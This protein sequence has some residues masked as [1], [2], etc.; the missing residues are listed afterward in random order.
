VTLPQQVAD[1]AAQVRDL[2]GGRPAHLARTSAAAPGAVPLPAEWA[3]D[4]AGPVLAAPV[5]ASGRLA[6][7]ATALLT[8]G[9]G[10]TAAY[11]WQL[12]GPYLDAAGTPLHDSP[13]GTVG[14]ADERA[15]RVTAG[16]VAASYTW[17]HTGLHPG[18]WLLSARY[19]VTGGAGTAAGRL[20]LA[21]PL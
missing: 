11:S 17:E 5:G 2:R 6:V 13:A 19:R 21:A 20:L 12:A 15:L 16:T 8:A 3:A 18:W 4:A 1:L 14:P 10:A 9:A 7:T